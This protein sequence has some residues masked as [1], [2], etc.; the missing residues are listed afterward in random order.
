MYRIVADVRFALLN[1]RVPAPGSVSAVFVEYVYS[2]DAP[3]KL[4]FT[5]CAP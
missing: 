1:L 3:P 5:P 4:P 2:K